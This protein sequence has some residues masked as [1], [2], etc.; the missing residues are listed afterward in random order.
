MNEVI[1][2]IMDRRSIR[3]YKQ[4]QIKDAELQQIMEAA[5]NAPNAMNQQKW[6][7]SVI[8]GKEKV[9]GYVKQIKDNILAS[10]NEFLKGRVRDTPD[11]HTFH[12]AQTVI[13]L[14]GEDGNKF[15]QVDC[16][17]AAENIVLAAASLGISSCVVA[18]SQML[19][20]SPRAK[21]VKQ[22]MG[23]P[24]NYSH[25]CAVTLG[26]MAGGNP[27]AKPRSQDVIT[28]IK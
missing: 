18:S 24:E 11:Y 22:E 19:F 1:K 7:F 27:E 2:A 12:H 4:E 16:G 28:Y 23:M 17:L 3:D 14:S 6:H 9:D 10:D 20:E 8:Q 21:Q 5:I 15:V 25:L 26:Y 13:M